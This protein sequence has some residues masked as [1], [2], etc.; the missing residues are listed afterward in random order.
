MGKHVVVSMDMEFN[1][2]V[3]RN[4]DKLFQLWY[5]D[6]MNSMF[7]KKSIAEGYG[8]VHKYL[9][10]FAAPPYAPRNLGEAF[11]S[12][13]ERIITESVK[14]W[15]T[16]PDIEVKEAITDVSVHYFF[17]KNTCLC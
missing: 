3:F 6:S 9:R 7:G 14:A 4:N 5:P 16:K 12:E 1:R 10:S 8:S 15:G 2:F 17:S 13:M 11:V